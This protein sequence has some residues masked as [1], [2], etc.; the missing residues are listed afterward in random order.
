MSNFGLM[1]CLFVLGH[2]FT[3][4][5]NNSQLAWRFWENKMIFAA[6]CFGVPALFCFWWATKIGYG[7][8]KELWSVRMAAF[9]ASYMIFPALTWFFLRESMFSP[10][11][12]I[13]IMLSLTIVSIQAFW[14]TNG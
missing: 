13:C 6:A 5:A 11:T 2:T 9:G 3:W 8:V 1:F 10:K 7:E 14:R 12:M 4:F